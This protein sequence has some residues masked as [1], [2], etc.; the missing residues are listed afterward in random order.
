MMAE[1][2]LIINEDLKDLKSSGYEIAD[3]EPD[4][5]GW[6]VINDAN[7]E[8]G[9][10][11]ELLFDVRYSKVRYLVVDLDGKPLNLASRDVLIP[12]GLAGLNKNNKTVV[13]TDITAGHLAAL[14]EYKKDK[15][16]FSTEREI[17]SVFIP[18]EN[19]AVENFTERL[20]DDERSTFYDHDHF[21]DE[22]FYRQRSQAD[23]EVDNSIASDKV[24]RAERNVVDDNDIDNDR[25][26]DGVRHDKELAKNE[27]KSTSETTQ[28]GGFAPFQEGVIEIKEHKEVPV[29]TKE[30][31][32]V[33]EITINKEVDESTE[34]VKDSVKKMK[35]DVDD[36]KD[37]NRD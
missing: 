11:D 30:A 34:T 1:E 14:P 33:E 27:T 7:V 25:D 29:V 26:N 8:I 13:I 15:V 10:V 6:K 31:R 16:F 21:D 5:R 23:R 24:K 28:E 18:E 4:I 9:E 12:I 3:G 32:V 36:I 19:N 17:R 35:V 37:K 2:K 22:K 20:G